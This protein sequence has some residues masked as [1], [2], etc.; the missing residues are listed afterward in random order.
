[1]SAR[2]ESLNEQLVALKAT[3]AERASAGLPV[4]DLLEQERRIAAELTRARSLL[5][6]NASKAILRG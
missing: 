5:T 1:M 6:E 4:E 2:L 3:I